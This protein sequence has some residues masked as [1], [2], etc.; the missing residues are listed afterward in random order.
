[1]AATLKP[2]ASSAGIWCRQAHQNSPNPCSSRISGAGGGEALADGDVEPDAVGRD[3]S[4][5]PGALEA[6]TAYADGHV[7]RQAQLSALWSRTTSPSICGAW[8]AARACWAA[9]L[10]SV[11]VWLAWAMVFSGGFTF[12]TSV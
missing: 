3:V 5:A 9:T 7:G 8:A 11:T 6:E 2:A 12:L 4:M 10:T 1:M